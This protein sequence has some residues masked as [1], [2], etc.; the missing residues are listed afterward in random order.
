MIWLISWL[1]YGIVVGFIAEAIY[2]G[3][4]CKGLLHTLLIG[5]AGSYV[6]GF[7]N[8]VIFGLGSPYSPSGIVMGVIGAIIVLFAYHKLGS[9]NG[10]SNS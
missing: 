1:I 6:G 9:N 7:L 8:Y 4:D 5:V 2:P 10:P 3:P